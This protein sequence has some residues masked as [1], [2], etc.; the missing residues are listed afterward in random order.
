MWLEKQDRRQLEA[1]QLMNLAWSST[2]FQFGV[3]L[4]LSLS[5]YYPTGKSTCWTPTDWAAPVLV[6]PLLA[7]GNCRCPEKSDLMWAKMLGA[8]LVICM[9]YDS[10]I[11]AGTHANLGE[12]DGSPTLR[13]VGCGGGRVRDG[14]RRGWA[15]LSQH[16]TWRCKGFLEHCSH[17]L[18]HRQFLQDVWVP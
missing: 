1:S 4:L 5:H 13:W 2:Y 8:N 3:L 9:L 11:R 7:S 18:K 15:S 16:W 10:A 12:R 17:F 6:P 14:L